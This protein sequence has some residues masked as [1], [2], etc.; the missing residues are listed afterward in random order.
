M[1]RCAMMKTDIDCQILSRLLVHLLFDE[2]PQSMCHVPEQNHWRLGLLSVVTKC[3]QRSLW[4]LECKLHCWIHVHY[5]CLYMILYPL[6]FGVSLHGKTCLSFV[7]N[8]LFMHFACSHKSIHASKSIYTH[9]TLK[10]S[11]VTFCPDLPHISPLQMAVFFTG[12]NPIKPNVSGF[13]MQISMASK[14]PT[15]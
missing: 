15:W 4:S 13:D 6:C 9:L 3:I 14:W 12:L 10:E 8:D 7:A 11:W 1:S 2:I 5:T